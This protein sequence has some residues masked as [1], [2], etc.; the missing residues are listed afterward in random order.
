MKFVDDNKKILSNL[1]EKKKASA[2]PPGNI[3]NY[4]KTTN[5]L[6]FINN[7]K[8]YFDEVINS[9]ASPNTRY[10]IDADN[11]A[12]KKVVFPYDNL[13]P[14][15]FLDLENSMGAL[16][17]DLT[18]EKRYG[19]AIVEV[20]GI[21]HV[22]DWFIK[23]VNLDSKIKGV[24]LTRPEQNLTQEALVLFNFLQDF[25]TISDIEDIKL[26]ITHSLFKH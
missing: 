10:T 20:R 3:K 18:I 7:T 13:S 15:W 19:E 22:E 11:T 2:I 12:V 17:D 14:P 16:K 8:D 4:I 23:K 26:G 21:K 9:I 1:L 24:F 5:L 25:G 6:S